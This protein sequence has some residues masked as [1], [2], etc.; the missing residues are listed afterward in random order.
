MQKI[1][2]FNSCNILMLPVGGI[3]WGYILLYQTKKMNLSAYPTPATDYQWIT[4]NYPTPEPT[5]E[6]TPTPTLNF[7]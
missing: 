6:P 3:K 2:F 4:N 7:I 1:S 5:P